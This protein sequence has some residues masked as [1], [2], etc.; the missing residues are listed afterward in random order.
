MSTEMIMSYICGGVGL[1]LSVLSIV[2]MWYN[3]RARAEGPQKELEKR[4]RAI[5]DH[6]FTVDEQLKKHD[7]YFENDNQR[8]K[9]QEKA[10]QIL[11]QSMLA[12]MNYLQSIPANNEKAAETLND[13]VKDLNHYLTQ[14]ATG[15][16][17]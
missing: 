17:V 15:K 9:T 10:T 5:D 1:V 8:L 2:N 3:L 14:K 4:F 16:E 7:M 13:A 11:L 6:F 12:I